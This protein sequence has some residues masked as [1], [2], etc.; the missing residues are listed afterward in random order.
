MHAF[1]LLALYM[2]CVPACMASRSML[3]GHHCSIASTHSIPILPF[4]GMESAMAQSAWLHA[5]RL[6][7]KLDR[8]SMAIS[9]PTTIAMAMLHSCTHAR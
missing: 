1:L 4:Q 9:C 6:E 3:P 5:S 7:R 2:L 8:S